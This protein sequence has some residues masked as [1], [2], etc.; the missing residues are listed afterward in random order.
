[1]NKYL[2]ILAGLVVLLAPVYAWIVDWAGFG[3]AA[4]SLLKG[5]L[6]WLFIL[7]GIVFLVAG[8]SD[9]KE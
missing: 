5:G 2:K 6:V 7:I 4:M 9:L 3:A 1:M 8:I